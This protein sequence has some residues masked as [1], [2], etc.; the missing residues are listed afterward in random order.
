MTVNEPN[1]NNTKNILILL[2]ALAALG[3]MIY[4]AKNSSKHSHDGGAPHAH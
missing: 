1:K 4:G 3:A 2:L